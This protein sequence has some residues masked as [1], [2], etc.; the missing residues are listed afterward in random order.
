MKRMGKRVNAMYR[1]SDR[2]EVVLNNLKEDVRK[3]TKK[4]YSLD[5]DSLKNRVFL[6]LPDIFTLITVSLISLLMGVFLSLGYKESL[7]LGIGYGCT[8]PISC[9]IV[10]W[11]TKRLP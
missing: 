11:I 2:L 6:Y 5:P 4:V 3:L 7:W 10:Y 8:G 1:D 9:L